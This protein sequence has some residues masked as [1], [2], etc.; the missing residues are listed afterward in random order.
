[1]TKNMIQNC[2]MPELNQSLKS[3]LLSGEKML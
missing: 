1:M 2:E 3:E